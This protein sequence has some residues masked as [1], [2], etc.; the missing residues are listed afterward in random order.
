MLM[1]LCGVCRVVGLLWE[2]CGFMM[3]SGMSVLWWSVLL[4]S[5]I[6]LSMRRLMVVV[7]SFCSGFL[8]M[9]WLYFV[10]GVIIVLVCGFC[11][12]LGRW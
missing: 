2:S 6:C 7:W 12:R 1:G 11:V 4:S 3:L 10:G 9:I 8:M 5:S